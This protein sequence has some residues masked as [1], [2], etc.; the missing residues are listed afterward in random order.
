MSLF[1]LAKKKSKSYWKLELS[2]G[3]LTTD[4]PVPVNVLELKSKDADVTLSIDSPCLVDVVIVAL[5]TLGLKSTQSCNLNR[6]A[7]LLWVGSIL[8]ATKS[9]ISS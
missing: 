5:A 2:F 8:V 1:F 7:G 6:P 3:I 4:E 9:G